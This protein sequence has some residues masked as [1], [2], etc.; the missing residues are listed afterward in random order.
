VVRYTWSV[1]P[2]SGIMLSGIP[3]GGT[4]TADIIVDAM[5]CVE[6]DHLMERY[7]FAVLALGDAVVMLKSSRGNDEFHRL[8][9]ES[10]E[11]RTACK[12]ALEELEDHRSVHGC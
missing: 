6:R 8:F 2:T 7:R 3:L 11:R 4:T 5:L 9:V 12:K 1:T 10:E